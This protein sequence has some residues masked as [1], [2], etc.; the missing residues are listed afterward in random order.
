MLGKDGRDDSLESW[1]LVLGKGG[2]AVIENVLRLDHAVWR[3]DA[4][5]GGETLGVL[6]LSGIYD[7]AASIVIALVEG[8]GLLELYDERE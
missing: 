8:I 3:Y 1:E 6:A 2:E 7:E 4:V 5:S